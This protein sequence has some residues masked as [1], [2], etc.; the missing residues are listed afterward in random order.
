MRRSEIGCSQPRQARSAAPDS[1]RILGSAQQ[2]LADLPT[3]RRPSWNARHAGLA[4]RTA[5]SGIRVGHGTDR[6]HVTAHAAELGTRF[7]GPVIDRAVS[8]LARF[9]P[10]QRA[11]IDEFL[12]AMHAV[13][14]A[15]REQQNP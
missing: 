4:R 3:G 9:T 5:G 10:E 7:F 2:N 8:E 6:S 12:T 11:T 13:V 1:L 15:T 14:A